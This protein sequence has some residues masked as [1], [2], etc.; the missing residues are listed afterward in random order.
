MEE[1][2]KMPGAVQHIVEK[3]K[4]EHV[5]SEV[6][7]RKKP[8]YL[9]VKRCFDVSVALAAGIILLFPMLVIAALVR[10]DSDGPALFKQERLGKDGRPFTIY[11][12]RTMTVDA[13]ANG[14]QWASKGDQRCTKLG[15]RLR[16]YRIDELPQLWNIFVGD[17]S[18]VGPR[19]ERRIFYDE[20]EKQIPGFKKRLVVTPGLTG[21][22]QVNGGY[23]LL[24]EEKIIYDMY[25]IE[26]QSFAM[27]LKCILMTIRVVLSGEGSR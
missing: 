8:L 6:T 22:A 11:K 4:S 2:N 12:F 27:D 9:L 24:P 13:E 1:G 16:T 14:P 7:P 25:Y 19:P 5:I 15:A 10:L 23:D 17:M 21:Y 20:F 26:N 18:I 3:T